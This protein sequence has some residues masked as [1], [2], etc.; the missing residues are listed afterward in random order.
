ML[1]TELPLY[2]LFKK[3]FSFFFNIDRL[4]KL[5]AFPFLFLVLLSVAALATPSTMAAN[6]V[7]NIGNFYLIGIFSLILLFI[8]ALTMVRVHRL[9][10]GADDGRFYVPRFGRE[11]AV[12]LW[13]LVR[14]TV[15]SAIFSFLLSGIVLALIYYF[16]PQIFVPAPYLVVFF[17]IW[18][19]FFMINQFAFLPAAAGNERLTMK[20]AW[21]LLKGNRLP[22]CTMYVFIAAFPFIVTMFA[23]A[24]LT[25][26]IP[27]GGTFL[28][29][30]FL[31]F[32]VAL[33]FSCVSQAVFMSYAYLALKQ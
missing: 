5:S 10:N 22:F 20:R 9:V 11:Y 14:L 4:W 32:E 16:V 2:G 23:G 8:L 17:F 25:S 7:Q 18:M 3:T 1:P 26:L 29:F 15:L 13:F 21:G 6:G 28:F 31:L 30:Q 12:Y 33:L 24:V 19:P 27:F